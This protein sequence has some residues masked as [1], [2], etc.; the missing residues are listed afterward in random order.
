[1]TQKEFSKTMVKPLQ[2][3]LEKYFNAA[4]NKE[5]PVEAYLDVFHEW[6]ELCQFAKDNNLYMQ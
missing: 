4:L 2:K 5:I 6:K 3:K 1:M